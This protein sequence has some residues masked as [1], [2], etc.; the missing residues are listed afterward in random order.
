MSSLFTARSPGVHKHLKVAVSSKFSMTSLRG[1]EPLIWN[2]T[3]IFMD[4]MLELSGAPVDLGTWLQWYAFDVIGSITFGERFGFMEERR[5]IKGMIE[6][7]E[8]GLWY[9]A[10]SGQLPEVHAYGLGSSFVNKLLNWFPNALEA[11]HPIPK[12]INVGRR[13]SLVLRNHHT[14]AHARSSRRLSRNMTKGRA[15]LVMGAM[16]SSACFE[17]SR[18]STHNGCVTRI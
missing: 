16:I 3:D 7:I 18:K 17:R 13:D 4:S 15:V 14:E 11:H 9:G 12:V 10:I 5:D 1:M 2:C 6:G 8:L